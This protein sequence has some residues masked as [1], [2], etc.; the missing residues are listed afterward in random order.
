MASYEAVTGAFS[1]KKKPEL[2]ALSL[3]AGRSGP[4]TVL[5]DCIGDKAGREYLWI[6]QILRHIKL[7]SAQPG[8]GNRVV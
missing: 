3:A 7:G 6:Y 1:V 8:K 5:Y 4:S 2:R